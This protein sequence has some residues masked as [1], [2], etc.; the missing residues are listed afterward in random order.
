MSWLTLTLLS[1]LVS[2]AATILQRVLMKSD[3]SNPYSY[4]I[5]FHFLLGFLTLGFGLLNGTDFSFFTPN[6]LLLLIAAAS[7]GICQVF[8]FKAL[9]LVEVSEVTILSG[10]RVVITIMASI[11]FL[12]EGFTRWNVLGTVLIL[13]STLLVTNLKRGFKFN[14]GFIYIIG[15]TLFGGLAI[16]LDSANVQN[17]EVL[18]YSTFSNF[19][20]GLFILIFY[21][22]AIL[23]WKTF[24]KLTFL[25]RMLPLAIFSA[26][27]GVLYLLALTYGGNT[28]E[29][30]TIRQSSVIITILLAVI[31]LKERSNLGRKLIAGA[32]VTLG[33]ILLS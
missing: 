3:K 33:V 29:V 7:W 9:Q 13:L 31:F 27:Q 8:L 14:A 1:V 23:Q 15:M 24:T 25:V 19:L 2:S 18:A 16:V 6:I 26:T 12:N 32:L 11:I 20:S 28:A 5:V 4:T 10:L 21:P 22:K 30:G 17:Y